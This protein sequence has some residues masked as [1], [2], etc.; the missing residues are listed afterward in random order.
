VKID[1]PQAIVP[2]IP[3]RHRY[4]LFRL[5]AYV[6]L[7]LARRND[8]ALDETKVLAIDRDQSTAE[9]YAVSGLVSLTIV[10]FLTDVMSIRI[11]LAAAAAIA[12]PA[13]ALAVSAAVV[14][15]GTCITPLLHAIG[16]PRGPHNINV[17]STIMLLPVVLAASYFAA[18][19]RWVRVPAWFFLAC[20]AANGL[21][22]IALFMLRNRVRE[23]EARCVA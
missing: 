5:V 15:T 3:S 7:L 16:L 10:L 12:I 17:N 4:A 22:A 14:L 18:S 8:Y 20:I 13:A 2:W 21:A 19:Q 11:H 9:T 6:R 1:R 23:A